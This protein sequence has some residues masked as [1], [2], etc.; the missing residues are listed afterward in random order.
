VR[1]VVPGA[2]DG[3]R[4]DRV[5]AMLTGLTRAEVADLVDAGDVRLRG[6][7]VTTRS[8]RV[9]EGDEVEVTVPDDAG[10]AVAQ[11]EADVEVPVVHVDDHVIVVDKP[12]DLVVHPGAGNAGGTLVQ[13]LLARFPELAAVGEPQRPGIVHR[14]D[15]GTSGLLVVARTPEAYASLVG[16]LSDRSVERRY[17]ALVWGVPEPARGMV[18]APIGRS[19]RDPTRMAVSVTGREARTSYEVQRVFA[20]PVEAAL[21][22]CKLETGRTHQIRVH[23]QAIGHPVVGDP[24]YRGLRAALPCPRPFL[25]AHRLAFD[26]PGTGGRVSFEAPLPADLADVLGGLEERREA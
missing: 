4:V 9:R 3:E 11:P 6:A 14:L 15:K 13:G 5:V 2:L 25:H 16:Q 8:V 17:T 12:P 20:E 23:L 1:E 18:D 22:A 26:H 19:R 7:A 24:R 21:V 10:P